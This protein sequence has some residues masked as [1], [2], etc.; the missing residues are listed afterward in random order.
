VLLFG[1]ATTEG[2][3]DQTWAWDGNRWTRLKLSPSPPGRKYHALAW[4]RFKRLAILFG[5]SVGE[6]SL[7]DLWE[8]AAPR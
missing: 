4:D 3:S 8:L 2:V 7:G 5:G 1:G 6:S